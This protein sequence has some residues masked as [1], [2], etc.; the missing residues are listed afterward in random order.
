MQI[1]C[2]LGQIGYTF[3]DKISMHFYMWLNSHCPFVTVTGELCA[4]IMSVG[5]RLDTRLKTR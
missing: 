5:G 3:E 1:S 4:Y 2:L